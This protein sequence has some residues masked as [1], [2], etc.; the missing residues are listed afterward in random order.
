[1]WCGRMKIGASLDPETVYHERIQQLPDVFDLVEF[2]IG[3]LA[4]DPE[5][6]NVEKVTRALEENDLDLVVHLPFRQPIVTPVEEYN[7]AKIKYNERLIQFCSRLGAE[8]AV[9]HCN[10]RWGQDKEEVMENLKEQ[11]REL[12]EIGEEHGVE[13]CFENIFKDETKPADLEE[14]G[15]ILEELDARMC[16]DIGHAV[17]EV[18]QEEAVEF[19]GNFSHL[20]SHLHIQDTRNQQDSHIAIGDGEIDFEPVASQL[21]G[22][23]GTVCLEIFSDNDLLKLSREKFLQHF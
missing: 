18:G 23:D 4:K 13:I 12:Q 19:L 16:F 14:F 5:M 10:L 2:S 8:K 15:E 1:M 22:F 6:I 17:A 7:R 11:M 20:L 9:A 21:S 3:E